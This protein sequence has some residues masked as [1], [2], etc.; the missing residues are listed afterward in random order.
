LRQL[1]D[2]RSIDLADLQRMRLLKPIV[3]GRIRAITWKSTDGQLDTVGVIPGA[4]GIRF[5]L[6]I[7]I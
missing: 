1:E 4:R 3:G 6:P 7:P 5:V 2:W